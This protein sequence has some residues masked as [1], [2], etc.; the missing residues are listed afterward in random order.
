MLQHDAA[1]MTH[2]RRGIPS[3][4]DSHDGTAH[5][6][7]GV[8]PAPSERT[9]NDAKRLGR[10]PQHTGAR[11]ARRRNRKVPEE[12]GCGGELVVLC[13]GVL[14]LIYPCFGSFRSAAYRPYCRRVSD[15]RFSRSVPAVF[16]LSRAGGLDPNPTTVVNKAGT[17]VL[18]A[19]DGTSFVTLREED[20]LRHLVVLPDSE[21]PERVA[22]SL[23]QAVAA[24]S[25]PDEAPDLSQ[26]RSI[27]RLLV[28]RNSVVGVST[29]AGSDLTVVIDTVA[30]ALQVGEWVAASVRKPS[31]TEL[32]RYRRW[33]EQRIGASHHSLDPK[34]VMVSLW[35]GG[36]TKGSARSVL[37][38]VAGS[39]P[40]F[41]LR[42]MTQP[43]GRASSVVPFAVAAA[44]S[45]GL[46]LV[47]PLLH[48]RALP[49]WLPSVLWI[50]AGVGAALGVATFLGRFP[51]RF[52]R[53]R[54]MLES[55]LVP[56]AGVKLRTPARPR[57]AGV[58]AH[59]AVIP[60]SDGDYPFTDDGFLMGAVLPVSLVAPHAGAE[61]GVSST[62]A[63]LAPPVL[64][65]R[66]GPMIGLNGGE[67][68]FLSS[69]DGWQGLL[70]IGQAGSGKSA[71]LQA[72]WGYDAFAKQS[73][74]SIP[75]A[76][77]AQHTMIALDT[78]GD[79]LS[80]QE[81]AEWARAARCKFTRIDFADEQGE[82]G[83]ELL[84][85]VGSATHKA[86]RVVGALKYV[87]GA[88][89]IGAESF[90]TLTRVLTA[91]FTVTPDITSQVEHVEAGK[92][93]FYY[94]N[95][96]LSNRGDDLGVQLAA[97]IA[98]KCSRENAQVGTDLYDAAE[99]LHPIYD[100]RRTVAQRSQLLK[101]PRTK[102]AALMEAEHWWSRPHRVTWEQLLT[103]HKTVIIN[104]GKPQRG[105]MADKEL[106]SQI[107]ALLMFTLHEEIQRHC[108][109]WFE[110]GKTVTVYADELKQVAGSSAAVVS[111][112]RNDARA[113]GV[114][115]AFATQYPEQL[116]TSVRD[117]VMG[118]GTMISFAQQNPMMCDTIV[119]NISVDG[120]R[121][122][123]ADVAGLR[124]YE[125]IVRT[126][127]RQTAQTAF[128]VSIPDFRSER[129]PLF[130]ANQG[131]PVS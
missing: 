83:I 61:S 7:D 112:I 35:A 75:G 51:S 44:V 10:S 21:A 84:P 54:S 91:A 85:T 114:R 1:T 79:G 113:F 46:A 102:V 42:T 71:L 97:A 4:D 68:V 96:L 69:G 78:K 127:F 56:T 47:M 107:S 115:A 111:W 63:R 82:L 100:P 120:S 80:A 64:R 88:D 81:Y 116:E 123:T 3:R 5:G 126:A 8:G 94:A 18:N 119:R 131:F 93:P 101:A 41:D 50:A 129:G 98:D 86:R 33:S 32:R 14:H 55:G 30:S 53:V 59:G 12:G 124:Q 6:R 122:T 11:D 109:G 77:G 125:A 43:F 29:Q 90:D 20:G 22:F 89:S 9:Q 38:R 121:W 106:V 24:R 62:K 99:M 57:R 67:P 16:R 104:T 92:S 34:A 2:H 95:I 39:L 15:M 117:A 72:L 37:T 105:F 27:V 87:F 26:T 128:T 23:A 66:V 103:Q 76:P 19:P 118:F 110:S 31:R 130:A 73:P 36:V 25:E 74:P 45:A 60:A 52:T 48:L 40:G 17:A 58:D 49:T 70:C 28:D 13:M 65:E 108:S